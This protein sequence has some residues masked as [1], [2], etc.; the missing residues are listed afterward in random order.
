[1]LNQNSQWIKLFG[2][3]TKKSGKTSADTQ[4]WY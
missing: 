4:L 3:H 1:V 2:H